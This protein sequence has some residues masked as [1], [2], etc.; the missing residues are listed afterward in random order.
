[1]KKALQL[2]LTA[3]ALMAATFAVA[4]LACD[5]IVIRPH[6]GQIESL[7]AQADPE[8]AAPPQMIRDMLDITAG[9]VKL[10]A[11]HKVMLAVSPHRGQGQWLVREPLWII[12]LPLHFSHSQMYGL[13]AALSYNGVDMGLNRF[14][15]REYGQ[16]LRQLT[17]L[18]AATTVAVT[19][20][21]TA[22]ADRRDQRAQW[23]LARYRHLHPDPAGPRDTGARHE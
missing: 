20:A 8:D 14:A 12:L 21:P 10:R 19:Y 6:L 13:Y 5:L 9:S 22:S 23:I 1:M 11:I 4:L 15:R 16:P 17:P 2:L 7:L 18:Q 3:I